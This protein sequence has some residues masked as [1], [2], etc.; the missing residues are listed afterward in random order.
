MNISEWMDEHKNQVLF[1]Y[2]DYTTWLVS[3]KLKCIFGGQRTLTS[4]VSKNMGCEIYYHVTSCQTFR[5]SYNEG[6]VTLVDLN[7]D[8]KIINTTIFTPNKYE[9]SDD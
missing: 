8:Q 2:D 9:W 6:N 7:E 3:K 4:Q 5:L 1:L